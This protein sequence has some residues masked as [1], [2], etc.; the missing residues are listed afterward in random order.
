MPIIQP[1]VYYDGKRDSRF[2]NLIHVFGV[3]SPPS[4]S[5]IFRQSVGASMTY[6]DPI[7]LVRFNNVHVE[8]DVVM[9]SGT[10]FVD[11][12][13]E[14]SN[15]ANDWS[16]L[17]VRNFNIDATRIVM[18][19]RTFGFETTGRYPDAISWNG[20]RYIRFGHVAASGAVGT[21]IA[22]TMALYET[23]Y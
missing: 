8:A 7:E 17:A 5:G 11:L 20:A 10:S 15:N 6:S 16:P 22:L 4:G 21:Q 2:S 18:E 12:Q 13:V 14:W 19:H 1:S 9:G 23:S 3:A